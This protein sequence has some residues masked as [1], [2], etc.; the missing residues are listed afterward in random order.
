MPVGPH[1]LWP[2]RREKIATELLHVERAM[3]GALRGIHQRG[4]AQ[5]AR[6]G[7]ELGNGINRAERVRDVGHREQLDFR[8][9]Q[10]VQLAHIQQADVAGDGQETEFAP[11]RSASNCHGTMLLWCSISVSRI[12]SPALTFFVPQR[13]ATRLMPSVVPRVKII[14]SA[15]RALMN[16]AARVRAA[17]NAAVARLLNSWMPRWTLALSCS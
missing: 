13:C 5:L 12:S 15:L 7:A 4:D 16:F 10:F 14:S 2:E 6:A 8:G 3:A 9:E 1:I 17:S 11:V